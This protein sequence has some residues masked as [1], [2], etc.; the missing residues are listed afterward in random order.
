MFY[1]Y[2]ESQPKEY[3]VCMMVTLVDSKNYYNN[4]DEDASN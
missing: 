2:F 3:S 1:F 4:C